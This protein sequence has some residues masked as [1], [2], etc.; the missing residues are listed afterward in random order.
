MM[1]L[2]EFENIV[3][4]LE[5]VGDISV[6]DFEDGLIELIIEDFEGFDNDWCEI[7]REYINPELVNKIE[8]L[9]NKI[10]SGDFYIKFELEGKEFILGYASYDI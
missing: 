9:A 1:T 4:E 7:E 6:Y 5:K 8:E 10:G 3:S 2:V